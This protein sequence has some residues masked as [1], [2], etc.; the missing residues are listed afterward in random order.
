VETLLAGVRV[1]L[2]EGNE[3][4]KEATLAILE[5][6]GASVKVAEDGDQALQ[7]LGE[8]AYGFPLMDVRMPV[9]DSL[10]ATRRIRADAALAH[11]LVIATTANAPEEDANECL[12][13]GMD[14]F[15]SRP[16]KPAQVYELIAQWA[17]DRGSRSSCEWLCVRIANCRQSVT[18]RRSSSAC[19]L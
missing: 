2:V 14:D 16:F 12:A 7:R 8:A 5:K 11:N 19:K 4:N 18:R 15:I 10:E 17:A 9:M 1:L 3:I 13:A 6:V